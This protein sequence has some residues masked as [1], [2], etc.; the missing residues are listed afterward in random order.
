M[1]GIAGVEAYGV[2]SLHSHCR[3]IG[4]LIRTKIVKFLRITT[5]FIG[6]IVP[7][8]WGMVEFGCLP[9]VYTKKNEATE[10]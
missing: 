9:E 1:V 6:N 4:E 7:W 5:I 8:G 3:V 10:R 2:V